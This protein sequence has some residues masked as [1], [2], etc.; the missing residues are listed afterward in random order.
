MSYIKNIGLGFI[1][2][3]FVRKIMDSIKNKVSNT[4]YIF[5]YITFLIIILEGLTL[6][7]KYTTMEWQNT[8][9]GIFFI[10]F[11][12]G[13]QMPLFDAVIKLV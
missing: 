4:I 3:L 13:F 10:T 6:C 8:T 2:G 7:C 1:L 12:F 9:P 11:F 5:T